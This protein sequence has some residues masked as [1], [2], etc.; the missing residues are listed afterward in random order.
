MARLSPE[1]Y[2]P[3]LSFRYRIQFSQIQDINIYG[4]AATLPTADNNPLTLDY[5]NTQIKV[6]SKTKWNDVEITCYAYEGLTMEQL[7]D[8][9]NTLHQD[10]KLGTDKYA[11]DYK[12]DIQIQLMSPADIVIGTWTLIGGFMANI[13]FGELDWSTEEVVQPRITLSYDYATFT[14]NSAGQV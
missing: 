8:Y 9:L 4:K 14:P 2:D 5:G 12:K 11:D 6:K 10:V 1:N 3:I 7:W 13:N